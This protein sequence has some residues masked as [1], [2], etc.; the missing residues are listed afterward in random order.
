MKKLLIL[1]TIIALAI[2]PA[3]CSHT[4]EKDP[5]STPNS[6][7]ESSPNE[8]AQEQNTE[9][10]DSQQGTKKIVLDGQPVTYDEFPL[11]TAE[12]FNISEEYAALYE[13]A[14]SEYNNSTFAAS[15]SDDN[16]DMVF[17]CLSLWDSYTDDDGNTVYV[18][19][20]LQRD[21]YDLGLGLADLENPTYN[22]GAGGTLA[23]FTLDKD[24]NL[25]DF[26]KCPDGS[27]DPDGDVRRICGPLTDLADFLCGVTDSY[28]KE[29]VNLPDLEPE[30]MVKQYL[31]YFFVNP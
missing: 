20:F 4:P 23:A 1:L 25:V 7:E 14:V 5:G 10:G 13:A 9:D 29:P 11:P 19:S 26:Q 28:P 3:G 8:Q 18:T 17:A 21:F 30:E 24:G 15:N 16:T 6:T 2:V 31:N 12:T 27:N 22:Y